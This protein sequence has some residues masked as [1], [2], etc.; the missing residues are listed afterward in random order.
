MRPAE[1]S[2]VELA[3][4]AAIIIA[5]TLLGRWAFS[6]DTY[7]QEG[8][9][10]TPTVTPTSLLD[11]EGD[12]GDEEKRENVLDCS[13][14][15]NSGHPQC[16]NPD[17][18][19]TP[20]PT[21]TRTPTPI[22]TPTKTPTPVTGP[23]I[24]FIPTEVP[25]PP[26]WTRGP[27]YAPGGTWTPT[28]KPTATNTPTDRPTS[29]PTY[30]P[31][32]VGVR[33][34]NDGSS[35]GPT[36]TPTPTPT[37]R[38]SGGPARPPPAGS[39]YA[40]AFRANVHSHNVPIVDE[41]WLIFEHE[42]LQVDISV[43]PTSASSVNIADFQFRILYNPSSTGFYGI[44]RF[45]FSCAPGNEGSDV[46][47]WTQASTLYMLVIRCGLGQTTNSGFEI[48]GRHA[49]TLAEFRVGR[50]GEIPQAWHQ[51]DQQV[52]F[53]VTLTGVVGIRPSWAPADSFSINVAHRSAKEAAD[54][55][56][57]RLGSVFSEVP[58][59][60][61]T[62][63][64]FWLGWAECS[65]PDA[66]ACY[67]ITGRNYPHLDGRTM[68]V[69]YPPRK[70]SIRDPKVVPK[71]TNNR[72]LVTR[73]STRGDYYYLPQVVAHEF[74]H[75]LGV[76]HLPFGHMMG[77]YMPGDLWTGPTPNDRRGFEQ[78]LQVHNHR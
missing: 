29:T 26:G 11:E 51:E 56:N 68:W 54:R 38:R 71:W 60:E 63:K 76:L 15:G 3:V 67:T 34:P 18:T 52:T 17:P 36:H 31:T 19:S 6:V 44:Q 74:G 8:G 4:W 32:P 57:S 9:S 46:S 12:D 43:V 48:Q 62:I 37:P 35:G 72:N 66:F 25:C 41:E 16:T 47:L 59:G 27:C 78:T 28:P 64:G 70:E 33:P 53:E 77:G 58:D 73:K 50:T 21:F 7:A 40:N 10:P 30:T 55:L 75:S 14:P 24:P 23:P 1:T 20:R 65:N 49:T 2:H 39:T 69:K 61:V 5:V 22:P 13:D 42:L 45:D